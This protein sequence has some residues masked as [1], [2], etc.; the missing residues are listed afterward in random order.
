MK[1]RT[2]H[3]RYQRNPISGI[4]S[5]LFAGCPATERSKKRSQASG[6]Y[7]RRLAPTPACIVR[8]SISFRN[9]TPARRRRNWRVGGCQQQNISQQKQNG[10][11]PPRYFPYFEDISPTS[12][13][14]WPIIG[15]GGLCP[16]S[17]S[18]RV[19]AAFRPIFPVL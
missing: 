3:Y 4:P 2:S 15:Y 5:A 14:D 19:R 16:L 7:Q 11:L 13:K 10:T 12:P 18:G 17:L 9:F 6:A 1:C 8:L